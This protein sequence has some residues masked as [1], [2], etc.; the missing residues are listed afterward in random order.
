M[1]KA[2]SA[3]SPFR[4]L[5]APGLA[6]LLVCSML[7]GLGVWQLQR[8]QWKEALIAQVGRRL[9]EAPIAAPGPGDWA[10]LDL[11][12]ADFTPVTVSGTF[13]NDQEALLYM[14]L[15]EP[16]GPLGGVGWLVFTPLKTDGGWIV[17]VNRG[18]VPDDHRLAASR[19]LGQPSGHVT[20]TG[21][22][23]RSDRPL[24]L[25][26]DGI[27]RNN[28]WFAREPAL[29]AQAAGLPAHDVAPYSIDADASPNPGGMPQGGETFVVFPNN[30]LQYAA[31]WFGLALAL[32]GV[33]IAYARGVMRRHAID[34]QA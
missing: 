29:F 34:L 27:S 32:I 18:F 1:S 8:L 14:T 15:S 26:S 24:H 16:K 33:F 11:A 17:Y 12:E 21:L 20:V 28:E 3:R 6:T 30:H 22:L 10:T 13:L 5:L 9:K 2:R 4:A 31:T 25:F 7:V 23:R 19:A